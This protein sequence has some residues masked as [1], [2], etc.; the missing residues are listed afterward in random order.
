ME[1]IQSQATPLGITCSSG[2]GGQ[3]PDVTHTHCVLA[4]MSNNPGPPQL[5]AANCQAHIVHTTWLHT[6][7][8]A[9]RIPNVARPEGVAPKN[10][11]DEKSQLELDFAQSWP[12]EDHFLPPI[13]G[14]DASKAD[15]DRWKPN[16]ARQHLL[17]HMAFL[18]CLGVSS[19][20][21]LRV[22]ENSD[23]TCVR[24]GSE[25]LNTSED[26]WRNHYTPMPRESC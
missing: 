15:Y 25:S 5:V 22:K 14:R 23:N 11:A 20:R 13:D 19:A 7:L 12:Q 6:L 24:K 16:P 2:A 21:W 26:S 18:D 1:A 17:K 8:Q 3:L 4:K 10:K 9:A